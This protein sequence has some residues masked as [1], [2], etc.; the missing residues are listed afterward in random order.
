[1]AGPAEPQRFKDLF[2]NPSVQEMYTLT[3]KEFEKF[4]AYVFRC[5]GYVVNDVSFRFTK[6]V[7]LE[8]FGDASSHRRSGGIEVKRLEPSALVSAQ[9]VQKLMGAPAVRRG[10]AAA[11]LVTTSGF[12]KAAYEMAA[13]GQRTYLLNGEQVCRYI[14]YVRGSRYDETTGIRVLI[15]PDRFTEKGQKAPRL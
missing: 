4:V 1:M 14:R 13:H 9:V 10:K 2:A 15:P 12:N 7:D 6:G 3:P 11:Y 8:L 5:A